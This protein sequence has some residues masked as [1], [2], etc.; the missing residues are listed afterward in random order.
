M[1][2]NWTFEQVDFLRKTYKEYPLSKTL[3]LYNLMFEPRSFKALGRKIAALKLYK[4]QKD[5]ATPEEAKQACQK[6]WRELSGQKRA[7]IN[8][9]KKECAECGYNTHT[10]ALDFHHTRDKAF[11]LAQASGHS[12]ESVDAE[13]AKCVVLCSNCHRLLHAGIISI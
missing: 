11:T 12:Y 4:Y 6:A 7:Y 13:I 8:S 10:S 5:G 9:H 1:N 2:H 3:G